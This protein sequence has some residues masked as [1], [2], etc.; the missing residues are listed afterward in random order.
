MNYLSEHSIFQK[1]GTI[2]GLVDK[3]FLLIKF[4]ILSKKLEFVVKVLSE[5]DYLLSFIFDT[6][7][8]RIK[9]CRQKT[10]KQISEIISID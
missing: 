9:S 5:N 6:I 7:Q 10:F 3:I 8:E 2:I 4:K 1:K